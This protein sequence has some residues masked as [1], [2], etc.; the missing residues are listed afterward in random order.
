MRS[1]IRS[2]KNA[3]RWVG[4]L[5]S[6]QSTKCHTQPPTDPVGG[7]TSCIN[8]A[9][10]YVIQLR[11]HQQNA[12]DK[13]AAAARGTIL[14]PTGGGKTLIAIMDAVR[15]FNASTTPISIIVV[16]PRLL[17]ANQ[18]CEEYMEVIK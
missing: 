18:L 16:A 10:N 4:S 6:S 2:V 7:Y 12:V 9:E 17:L 5:S 1:I 14:V 13:M 8:R 11:P 3:F 15:R